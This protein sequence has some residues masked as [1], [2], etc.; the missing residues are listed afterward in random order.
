MHYDRPNRS[1]V[2]SPRHHGH[3]KSARFKCP[4][5][6]LIK[7]VYRGLVHSCSLVLTE[8]PLAINISKNARSGWQN[9]SGPKSSKIFVAAH[10]L[11]G[12]LIAPFEENNTGDLEYVVVR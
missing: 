8:V 6:F 12:I 4:A 2:L 11:I 9:A 3:K 7:F 1:A 10:F 5:L